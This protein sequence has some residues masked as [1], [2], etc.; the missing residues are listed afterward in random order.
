MG[1]ISDSDVRN[2]H[3]VRHILN[4]LIEGKTINPQDPNV[5]H[6]YFTQHCLEYK[7]SI[8]KILDDHQKRIP[9]EEFSIIGHNRN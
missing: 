2:L 1:E 4:G 3:Q 5:W 7:L 6:E 9:P 8:T